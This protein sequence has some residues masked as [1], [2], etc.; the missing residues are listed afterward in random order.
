[1][2]NSTGTYPTAPH[3]VT[4]DA[5]FIPELWSSEIIATY[6]ASLV[7]A[8]LVKKMSIPGG[9]RKGDTI[10]VPKPFRGVASAKVA[11]QD[12]TLNV[13]TAEELVIDID[14]HFDASRLIEDIVG[15]QAL[16]SNRAFY[17]NDAGYALA[18]QVDNDLIALGA[19]FG[20]GATG[21]Y[22]DYETALIG[23][24]S[25]VWDPDANTN[26][27][28]A[29]A[30]TDAGL[31]KAIQLLDDADVPEMGRKIVIP[32]VA[33][34]TLLGIDRFNSSDFRSDGNRGV[35]S[36]KFGEVYGIPVFSTSQ[37]AVVEDTGANSNERAVLVFHE[38][39]IVH[40]E[41]MSIRSQTQ[42]KLEKLA[43]LM[44]SDTIYGV[45][46]YR[47]E[48]GVALVIPS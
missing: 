40:V 15:V 21:T 32:P 47:E 19:G 18:R 28:N 48:A 11:G 43:T 44:V 37:A 3:T 6:K 4:T 34:N 25:A 38:D 46:L 26:Q 2:A 29:T 12:V 41:Q 8:N 9:G 45:S 1:M 10:H 36:G 17:T 24:G 31:R 33:K 42:E 7:M 20:A 23:D 39:A 16:E 30:L 27:G 5:V 13:G 35:E 14:K 22:T